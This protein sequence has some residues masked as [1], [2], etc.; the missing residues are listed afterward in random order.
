MAN[1]L[2]TSLLSV[3]SIKIVDERTNAIKWPNLKV[4]SVEIDMESDNTV[5]PLSN[6]QVSPDGVHQLLLEKDLETGKIIRPSRIRLSVWSPDV[7]TTNSI[8][9]LF[10]DQES[11]IQ[12]TSKSIISDSMMI[13][14]MELEQTPENI[15]SDA[16]TM[17]LEQAIPPNNG[18]GFDPGQASDAPT[19]GIRIQMPVS[20]SQSVNDLYN[21]LAKTIGV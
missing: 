9:Q 16:I 6:I 10:L 1:P 15:T 13:V 3:P 21:K 4:R 12:V 14:S 18:D 19:L 11:T 17:E 5:L 20:L 8:I 2:I 7:S